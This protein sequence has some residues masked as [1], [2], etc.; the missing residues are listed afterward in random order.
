MRKIDVQFG[1]LPHN[2]QPTSMVDLALAY[3]YYTELGTD[4]FD[5]HQLPALRQPEAE[6]RTAIQLIGIMEVA[7]R[8]SQTLYGHG[9]VEEFQ[10][11]FFTGSPEG[12]KALHGAKRIEKSPHTSLLPFPEGAGQSMKATI[13]RVMLEAKMQPSRPKGVGPL[14][15]QD[16]MIVLVAS[17]ICHWCGDM[18]EVLKKCSCGTAYCCKEC[19]RAHWSLHKRIEHAL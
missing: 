2:I 10:V 12:I 6:V 19:Q 5:A 1:S 18:P 16:V 8:A 9:V 3:Q 4:T 17:K 13:E 11:Y 14:G 15:S 7:E